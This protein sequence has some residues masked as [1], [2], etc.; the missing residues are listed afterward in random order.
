MEEASAGFYEELAKLFPDHADK[1]LD[2][3]KVNNKH[4]SNVQRT[5]FGVIEPTASKAASPSISSRKTMPSMLRYLV[6]S[7]RPMFSAKAI[8]AE[9]TI[10]RF[11]TD[12]GEQGVGLTADVARAFT[13]IARKK[14]RPHRRVEGACLA[15]PIGSAGRWP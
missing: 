8:A 15:A 7:P 5:Y 10:A 2:Y 4:V 3:A 13:P 11:Y 9:E 1:F 12:A 6:A 14:R